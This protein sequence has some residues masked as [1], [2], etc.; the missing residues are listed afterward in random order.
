[1]PSPAIAADSSMGTIGLAVNRSQGTNGAVVR[2]SVAALSR[3]DS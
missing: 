3:A 1:M 2:A